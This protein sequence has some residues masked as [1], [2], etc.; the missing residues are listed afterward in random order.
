MRLTGVRPDVGG[1]LGTRPRLLDPTAIA[2]RQQQASDAASVVTDGELPEEDFPE[3]ALDELLDEMTLQD[4]DAAP[5][6]ADD[7][8]AVDPD[9]NADAGAAMDAE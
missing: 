7:D 5:D 1:C 2:R 9:A 8:A 6:A 3:I 4:P